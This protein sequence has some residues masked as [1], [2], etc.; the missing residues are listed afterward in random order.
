MLNLC[1]AFD[2]FNYSRYLSFQHVLLRK[3]EREQSPEFKDLQERGFGGRISGESFSAIHGDLITEIYNG[4]TKGAA[5]PFRSGYST[6]IETVN[7]WVKTAHIHAKLRTALKQKI[8]LTT[9][10]V[11][12]EVTEGGKKLHMNHMNK[13]IKKLHDYKIDPFGDGPARHIT[14]G[15]EIDCQ[16]VNDM[17]QAPEIGKEKCKEFIRDRLVTG[18]VDYFQPIKRL[19][20]K[21]GL[22]K[23]VKKPKSVSVLK[24][25]RQAFGT[26][27]SQS[28]NLEE[29][30][31][32][33]LTL[34]PLSIATPDGKAAP[35]KKAFASE[36]HHRR[37]RR[38]NT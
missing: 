13:L 19:K 10:T 11:H 33:P 37:S 12:K 24:E 25:D 38:T 32:Y 26:M 3:H 18:E 28:I 21:T 29:A 17:L 20:L 1:F 7:T 4:E 22:A 27:L 23:E 2:H 5:G 8:D 9:S 15:R 14:T 16:I 35:C 31:R 30:L 36:L 6:N 34:V